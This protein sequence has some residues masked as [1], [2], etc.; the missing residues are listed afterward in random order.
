MSMSREERLAR[1]DEIFAHVWGDSVARASFATIEDASCD[2]R[3][4]AD[5]INVYVADL[6]NDLHAHGLELDDCA[7]D[8]LDELAG[9]VQ[10]LRGVAERLE[11]INLEE[12][13][14]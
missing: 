11:A 9:Y 13:A 14:A 1:A 7:F 8:H 10:V 6:R 4:A 5:D 3:S 12:G 2:L